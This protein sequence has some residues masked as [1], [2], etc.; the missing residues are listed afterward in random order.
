[1]SYRH[2][3]GSVDGCYTYGESIVNV[4]SIKLNQNAFSDSVKLAVANGEVIDPEGLPAN[5]KPSFLLSMY[6]PYYGPDVLMTLFPNYPDVIALLQRIKENVLAD[7]IA[8]EAEKN[9][10]SAEKKNS[11]YYNEFGVLY[12]LEAAL[13]AIPKGWR[14]PTEDDWLK[15]EKILGM[16][17]AALEEIDSWRAVVSS[18]VF[19]KKPGEQEDFVKFGGTYASGTFMVG[20]PYMNR[21]LYGYYWSSSEIKQN[22]STIL[23][24]FRKFSAADKRIYRGTNMRDAALSVKCIKND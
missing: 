14:L 16:S 13:S 8:V 7:G 2:P 4:S 21:G 5:K 20:T 3:L 6:A 12:T 24:Y 11:Y 23:N 15:L 17:D 9:F 1:M 10:Q 18:N 19:N 22:D